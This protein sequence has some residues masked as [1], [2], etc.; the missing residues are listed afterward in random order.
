M[1]LILCQLRL[2]K[3][4]MGRGFSHS[5]HWCRV[6]RWQINFRFR[7]NYP[8]VGTYVVGDLDILPAISS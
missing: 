1:V 6:Q 4:I 8:H 7:I 3:G 5:Q 2:G